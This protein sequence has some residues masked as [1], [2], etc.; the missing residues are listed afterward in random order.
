MRRTLRRLKRGDRDRVNSDVRIRAVIILA[1]R[2]VLRLPAT[3]D[4]LADWLWFGEVGYRRSTRP[5]S[6]RSCDGGR[7]LRRRAGWLA[8]NARWR[9]RRCHRRR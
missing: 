8:L 3:L 2:D 7:H 4:F 9:S 1:A 5:R 6:P